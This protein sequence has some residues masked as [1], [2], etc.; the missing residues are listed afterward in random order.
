MSQRVV[1][2]DGGGAASVTPTQTPG[3]SLKVMD[4]G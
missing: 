1:V 4:P 2:V 3:L